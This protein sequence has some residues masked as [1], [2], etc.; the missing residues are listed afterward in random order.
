MARLVLP[1]ILLP[2]A[3][4]AE[5]P[6][7]ILVVEQG[8]PDEVCSPTM[9]PRTHALGTYITVQDCAIAAHQAGVE[10]FS[11]EPDGRFPGTCWKERVSVTA[12]LFVSWSSGIGDP[13]CPGGGW[14]NATHT[15]TYAFDPDVAR[16]GAPSHR[17]PAAAPEQPTKGPADHATAV[18]PEQP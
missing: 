14:V 13:V 3:A 7:F 9:D 5:V 18:A 4:L 1:S 6:E 17:L 15:N 11:Y 16:R 8:Y 2:L 12:E 10:T